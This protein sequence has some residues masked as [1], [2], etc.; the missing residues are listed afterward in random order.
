MC[1][2]KDNTLTL[3]DSLDIVDPFLKILQDS[4]EKF[5]KVSIISNG[6]G[7]LSKDKNY[8]QS[9][10]L[11]SK[12]GIDVIRHSKPKPFCTMEF[13]EYFSSFKKEEIV[14]IGDR[15]FTDILMANRM[16]IKSI[17]VYPITKERESM[18]VAFLRRIEFKILKILENG[19]SI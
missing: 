1:F 6:P 16:G 13:L 5:E 12:Y 17:F 9:N 7:N 4:R 18:T 11:K 15:L 10:L 14:L 3:P 19:G 8:I 2:D